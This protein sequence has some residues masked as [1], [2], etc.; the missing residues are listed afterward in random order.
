VN[1][2]IAEGA[3]LS[4]FDHKFTFPIVL[5]ILM[6]VVSNL[7]SYPVT[8]ALLT[9]L[10]IHLHRAWI[11]ALIFPIYMLSYFVNLGGMALC[12]AKYSRHF[13]RWL[14]RVCVE[15]LLS[16][17]VPVAASNLP[18]PVATEAESAKN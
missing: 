13:L 1:N 17:G 11:L 15:K 9:Y 10:A 3:D 7:M 8:A 18:V 2:A 4:A 5:G 12:G 6:I 14:V 16:L